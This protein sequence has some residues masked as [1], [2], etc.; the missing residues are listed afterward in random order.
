MLNVT[1]ILHLL[2]TLHFATEDFWLLIFTYFITAYILN[3]WRCIWVEHESR[4]GNYFILT[5]LHLVYM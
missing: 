1:R 3:L 2:G 5:E 4:Q